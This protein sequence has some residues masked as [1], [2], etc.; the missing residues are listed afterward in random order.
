MIIFESL[1]SSTI[2]TKIK[3]IIQYLEAFAPPAY[4][5]SYDNSGLIVGDSQME[6][7][8]I[9]VALDC[10]EKVV[11][12][13]IEKKANLIVAHHPIVF[14]GL[15]KLTGNTYVERTVMKAIKKDVS[16]Y[17]IH[18]NLDSIATGVNKKISDRDLSYEVI[19]LAMA[20]HRKL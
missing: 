9:L 13:A 5:E 7:N 11:D 3:D 6:L 18:T 4:Q 19:G 16:I 12:E 8:G 10:T 20:V 15:K 14:R 2:M 17:A 1:Q